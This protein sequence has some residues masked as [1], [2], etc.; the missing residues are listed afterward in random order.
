MVA[1]GVVLAAPLALLAI[2]LGGL[3]AVSRS[4]D[5]AAGLRDEH[6]Y[7]EAVSAYLAT[8][9]RTGPVFLLARARVEQAPVEAGATDLQWAEQLAGIGMVDQAL[10][11]AGRVDAPAL[12]DR[13]HRLEAT[14]A[15]DAARAATTD[16]RY[17]D[18][19]RRLDQV[20]NGAPPADLAAEASALRPG[21]EVGAARNLLAAGHAA[22]AVV[23]L[24]QAVAGPSSPDVA[25]AAVGLLPAALLAAGR[26]RAAGGDAQ[27]GAQLL[28]RL[29]SAYPEAPQAAAARVLLTAPQRVTGTLIGREGVPAGNE[30]VRLAGG[31][32][33][34][35]TSFTLAGPFLQART[36]AAG[37]FHVDR[38]SVGVP[39]V[40][41]FLDAAGWELVVDDNRAPAYAVNVQPLA[42]LDLGFIREP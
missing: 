30:Q 28:H 29:L 37:S 18:A 12:L 21:I 34:V 5:A 26:E 15:L 32:R 14:I 36:D 31:Y 13:A 4:L 38:V 16:H 42:P 17:D 22:E 35:G 19:L 7:A 33:R 2:E 9:D 20:R 39:M 8:A 1:V 23:D 10:D 25:T 41:E 27:E 3:V 40:L 11:V 6:R 24:D